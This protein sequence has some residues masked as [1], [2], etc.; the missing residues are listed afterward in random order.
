MRVR[1]VVR[2][3]G[4]RGWVGKGKGRDERWDDWQ[5]GKDVGIWEGGEVVGS[6]GVGC[7]LGA[8]NE[9]F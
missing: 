6:G 7:T 1:R 2:C 3:V 9:T 8:F 4:E 5:G